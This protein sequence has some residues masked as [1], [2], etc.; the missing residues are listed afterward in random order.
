MR[1]EDLMT[2]NVAICHTGEPLLRA[3][4][5]M[6]ERDTGWI[7]VVDD[8]RRPVGVVTDR[9]VAYAALDSLVPADRTVD[10]VMLAPVVVEAHMSLTEASTAMKEGRRRRLVV[11]DQDARLVG[12]L[13]LSDLARQTWGTEDDPTALNTT[14]VAF[15]LASLARPRHP[16]DLEASV[17]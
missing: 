15:L 7:P 13:S 17:E 3:V 12:V 16:L 10:E 9:A 6:K 14:D 2:R 8:E 4:E 1:V 5:H 11:V